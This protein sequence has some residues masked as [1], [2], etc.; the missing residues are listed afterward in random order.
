MAAPVNKQEMQLDIP[1]NLK[2]IIHPKTIWVYQSTTAFINNKKNHATA[3]RTEI[4]KT[5]IIYAQL[6]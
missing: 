6:L 4:T 1:D 3:L 2:Y 5:L